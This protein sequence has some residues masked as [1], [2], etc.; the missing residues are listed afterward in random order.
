[1]LLCGGRRIIP[2]S[3]GGLS[4]LNSNS[5]LTCHQQNAVRVYLN[6]ANVIDFTVGQIVLIVIFGALMFWAGGKDVN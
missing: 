6:G 3:I 1:M 2:N 5:V 4:T